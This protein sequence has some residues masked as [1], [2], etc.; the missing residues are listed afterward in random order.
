M[1]RHYSF[2]LCTSFLYIRCEINYTTETYDYKTHNLM[3]KT[4]WELQR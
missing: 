3:P 4:L 1:K 2:V